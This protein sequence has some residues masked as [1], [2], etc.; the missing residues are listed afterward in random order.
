M[1]IL[2]RLWNEVRKISLVAL[3]FACC[4]GL[5]MLVKELLLAEYNIRAGGL[6]F[7]MVG[8]FTVAKVVALLEWVSFGPWVRRRP[9]LLDVVLRSV[10]YG[11]GVAVFLLLEKAF[12]IRHEYGS[13]GR[14]VTGVFGH[15]E[16]HQVWLGVICIGLSLLVY[17]VF[18]VVRRHF[19]W[20]AMRRLF[21]GVSPM[22]L[23][24]AAQQRGHSEGRTGE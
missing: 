11:L 15:R 2:A 13:F 4:F 24:A 22:E 16:I 20:D 21:L 19:G 23:D 12:E 6:V 9:V 5:L 3:Y 14:A 17:N 1:T 10:V 18:A 7:A 8:A